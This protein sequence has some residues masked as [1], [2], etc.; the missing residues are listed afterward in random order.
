[1]TTYASDW[2]QEVYGDLRAH[3]VPGEPTAVRREYLNDYLQHQLV[4]GNGGPPEIETARAFLRN[5]YSPLANGAW[6]RETAWGWTMVPV[7]QMAA[8]LAA[9][10]DALRFF[11]AS[12][13][14]AA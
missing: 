3:A 7:E 5:A 1:M 14:T 8:Y 9:Q 11:S 4:P 13:G 10:V 12:T 6:P 2:S